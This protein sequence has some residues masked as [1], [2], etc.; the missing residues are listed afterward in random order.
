MRPIISIILTLAFVLSC[1][2]NDNSDDHPSPINKDVYNFEFI[3]YHVSNIV[4]YKGPMGQKTDPNETYLSN[5]WSFY[6]EPSWKKIS[7]DLKN[8]S[9]QLISGTSTNANHHVKI[10]ND[11]VFTVDNTELT[12][13]G[14]FNKTEPTFTLK[15]SFNYIKK[16]PREHGNG[17]LITQKNIFGTTQHKNIFGSSIFNSP[18]DMTDTGDLV[19]WGNVEYTFKKL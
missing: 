5:Y 7:L 6:K 9:I 16:M 1:S 8:N 10:V 4:L 18:A 15:R 12:Y 13:I 2:G 17:L 14:T 3:N 11:S 19:L